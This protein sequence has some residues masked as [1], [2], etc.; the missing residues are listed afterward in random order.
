MIST[1]NLA[2]NFDL[3]LNYPANE[4]MNF[5]FGVG[6]SHYQDQECEASKP[7]TGEG[8]EGFC[9]SIVS[10]SYPISYSL[11]A[12]LTRSL[13]STTLKKGF[14]G[15]LMIERE[16]LSFL[17]ASKETS[18]T[19]IRQ[20][21][22]ATLLNA[23]KSAYLW[24]TMG[25]DFNFSL[26]KKQSTLSLLGSYCLAGESNLQS[27]TGY[28]EKLDPCFKVHGE[29]K[30]YLSQNLW[31]NAYFKLLNAKGKFNFSSIHNGLN[32]GYTF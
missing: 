14:A 22:G 9:T 3:K 12:G 30:Q 10:Y 6:A 23:T 26:W 17:S 20:Y 25:L 19:D 27:S 5:F 7:K 21:D 28:W 18:E 29:Y 4:K 1:T 11:N 2:F 8:I 24:L 15:T 32:L 13:F 16:E 31:F